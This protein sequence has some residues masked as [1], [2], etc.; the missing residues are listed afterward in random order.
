M[1]PSPKP[2]FFKENIQK[3]HDIAERISILYNPPREIFTIGV[4]VAIALMVLLGAFL[5]GSAFQGTQKATGTTDDTRLKQLQE[6]T[7]QLN[8]GSGG[9]ATPGSETAQAPAQAPASKMGLDEV[10][11]IAVLI[12]ITPYAIDITLQKRNIRRKRRSIRSS[13]SSSPS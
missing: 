4:P 6:L 13:S 2:D 7:A 3:M 5:T 8:Q 10:L 1:S 9:N 11:V 12:A